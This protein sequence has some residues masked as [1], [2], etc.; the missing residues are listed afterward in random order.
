MKKYIII[1][2]I[3]FLLLNSLIGLLV[4]EYN[5]FNIVLV[6]INILLTF[7]LFFI[8]AV[9]NI[10]STYKITLAIVF[11]FTGSM[12]IIA[13]FS[14]A[15]FIRNNTVIIGI[16]VVFAIEIL[17]TILIHSIKKIE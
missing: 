7:I 8:L 5:G 17:L 15:D 14:S 1:I 6:D 2:G 3:I 13:A 10:T 16:L 4:T 11:I 12:R 9:L